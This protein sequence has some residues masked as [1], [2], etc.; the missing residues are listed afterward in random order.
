MEGT[1]KYDE[2]RMSI[3]LFS[4]LNSLGFTMDYHNNCVTKCPDDDSD[5]EHFILE[6]SSD[7]DENDDVAP[8]RI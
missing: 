2:P 7:N 3:Y 6:L 8:W 5:S 1:D 4:N